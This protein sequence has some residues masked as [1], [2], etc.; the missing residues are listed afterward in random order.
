MVE[1]YELEEG[2]MPQQRLMEGVA[3][4][5]AESSLS[6]GMKEKKQDMLVRR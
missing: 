5:H 6:R 1:L 2:K 4:E 3:F